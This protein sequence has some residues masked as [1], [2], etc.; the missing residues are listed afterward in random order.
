MEDPV[1]YNFDPDR[2]LD[3]EL[4]ALDVA[5]NAGQLTPSDYEKQK[6]L[7]MERYE[8]MIDRLDG[9]Y[10]IAKEKRT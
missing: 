7:L 9:T 5:F 6:D 4:A 3:N 8:E 2:W 10:Q 1:T